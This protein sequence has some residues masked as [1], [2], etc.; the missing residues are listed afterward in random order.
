MLPEGATP[1]DPDEMDGLIPQHITTQVELDEWEQTN[2][3]KAQTWLRQRRQRGPRDAA[4]V[5]ELHW[6]MFDQTWRWAGEYRRSNKNIG[7]SWH[8]IGMAIQDLLADVS[9]WIDTGVYE[10]DEMAARLH[11]RLV[12]VHPF[13]NGNGRHSRLYV[14][15]LL[16]ELGRL[17]FSWGSSTLLRE[18]EARSRYIASLRAADRGDLRPLLAFVRT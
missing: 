4:F 5:R 18:G 17:P 8:T 14:D 1:L 13:S 15:D 16:A 10:I 6:R 2:I 3:G 7:V 9:L 12:S 11:H